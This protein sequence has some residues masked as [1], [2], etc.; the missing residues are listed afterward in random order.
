MGVWHQRRRYMCAV[1][2]FCMGMIAWATQTGGD[3][4]V[5]QTVVL[6]GFTLIGAITGCYVFGAAWDDKNAREF[7]L[8]M[9]SVNKPKEETA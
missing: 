4:V 5:L 9:A 3:S 8:A 1:T 2:A 7:A 6:G